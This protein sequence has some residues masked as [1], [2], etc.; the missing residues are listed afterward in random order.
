M[1]V[2]GSDL[3]MIYLTK[4]KPGKAEQTLIIFLPL[5]TTAQKKRKRSIRKI[6]GRKENWKRE[7]SGLKTELSLARSS[8]VLWCDQG[9]H[10]REM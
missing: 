8:C 10:S 2:K 7:E 6:S 1:G 9:D 4:R 3:D 5:L